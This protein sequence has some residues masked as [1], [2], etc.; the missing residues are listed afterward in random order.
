MAILK[1]RT[2][3]FFRRVLQLIPVILVVSFLYVLLRPP[4]RTAPADIKVDMSPN[5]IA[6]GQYIFT[7]LSACDACHSERDFSKADAPVVPSGRGKGMV[8]PFRELPGQIVASN[9]TPDPETGLGN[10]TDGEKIRAIREGISKDGRALFPLMPYPSYHIMTDEDVQALVAY[11]DSLPAIKNALPQTNVSFPASMLMKS[12][13]HAAGKVPPQDTDGGEAYGE[14][15]ASLGACVDCHTPV[16]RLLDPDSSLLFAGGRLFSTPQ[17]TVNSSNITP[18]KD[19]GI[20]TW[21]FERFAAAMQH[22]KDAPADPAHY[23][24]MPWQAY[25]GLT[26]PD[27]EDI[28]LYLK[29][30]KPISHQVTIHP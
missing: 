19:T 27:L 8:M 9:L 30:L 6:R 26:G 23:T 5:R 15:L 24:W 14:Y 20:G 11:M 3:K 21:N 2:K 12:L 22:F 4:S 7:T 13:P 16:S 29:A 17:G 28:F 1:R 18:D 10:W 25:A